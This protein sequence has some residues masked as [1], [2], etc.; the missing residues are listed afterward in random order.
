MRP[1]V[2]LVLLA[3]GSGLVSGLGSGCTENEMARSFGGTME[4]DLPCGEKLF[5]LTWKKDDFWYATRPMRLAEKAETYT[6]RSKSS[7][8]VYEG[9][10]IV[11][12]CKK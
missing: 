11:K 3:L 4:V 2:P 5:D 6:F 12:E 10:V 1:L 7:F 9:T 8:G